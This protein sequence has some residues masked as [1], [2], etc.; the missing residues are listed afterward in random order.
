MHASSVRTCMLSHISEDREMIHLINLR[1]KNIVENRK[2]S[3]DFLFR[4][5]A[6]ILQPKSTTHGPL[7]TRQN[8]IYKPK[9]LNKLRVIKTIYKD[10]MIPIPSLKLEHANKK[11]PTC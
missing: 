1:Y 3:L 6:N 8:I 5:K 7:I 11:C 9:A 10:I 4:Q 2:C